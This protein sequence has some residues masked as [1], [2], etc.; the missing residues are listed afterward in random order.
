MIKIKK[1]FLNTGEV[2]TNR[3]PLQQQTLEFIKSILVVL[4]Q[5]SYTTFWRLHRVTEYNDV[6][7]GQRDPGSP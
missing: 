6:N 5:A 4:F 3:K 1:K 2:M 7:T